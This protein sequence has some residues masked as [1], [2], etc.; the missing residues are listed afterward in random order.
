MEVRPLKEEKKRG[1]PQ[2]KIN[3]KQF[4][5][6]CEIQ[7]TEEEICS[8]LDVTDKTLNKWCNKEYNKNFSEVFK[9]KRQGGKT[10]LRRKQWNL[11]ETNATM[12]IWLGKQYLEQKDNVEVKTNA[13]EDLTTL[14]DMLGFNKTKEDNK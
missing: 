6:L 5:T 10:S 3:K 7:C 12:A 14:A 13:I 8:V 9:Q 4:E 1:A 2:K 11:A